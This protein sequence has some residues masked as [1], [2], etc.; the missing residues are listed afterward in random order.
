M[1][2]ATRDPETTLEPVAC[3]LGSYP[4]KAVGLGAFGPIILDEND[5]DYGL[6]TE[7]PKEKWR[8]FNIYRYCAERLRVPVY[9]DTD[10]GVA[11][12]GNISQRA[13]P[14]KTSSTSRS[15]PASAS[16]LSLTGKYFAAP[17]TP[18]WVICRSSAAITTVTRPFAL[19]MTI[20]SRDSQAGAV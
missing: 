7:T 4:L 3:F 13:G 8:Q 6:I 14:P 20:V 12:L 15:G 18:N 16:A 9:L 11:A 1:T 17:I 5:P 2:I 10:V 19:I